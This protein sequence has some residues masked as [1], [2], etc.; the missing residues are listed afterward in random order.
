MHKGDVETL[1]AV[2]SFQI[3]LSLKSET[4]FEPVRQILL[5]L[6]EMFLTMFKVIDGI[7]YCVVV[8]IGARANA[9]KYKYTLRMRTGK[10][11]LSCSFITAS[12]M[13]NIEELLNNGECMALRLSCIKKF[14]KR[15]KLKID[16][17]ILE[18][19]EDS[20]EEDDDE[21]IS[22][23]EGEGDL[24]ESRGNGAT[25]QIQLPS[26]QVQLELLN[27]KREEVLVGAKQSNDPSRDGN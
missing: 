15:R 14:L 18:C 7:F 9:S 8:H 1:Y 6:E 25:G 27:R 19:V 26:L 10:E 3:L 23:K 20:S 2:K 16:I 11:A 4:E 24:E 5:A 22:E 21:D 17:T 13:D 12:F